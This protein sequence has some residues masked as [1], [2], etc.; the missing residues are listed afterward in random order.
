M[1]ASA[2]TVL[3]RSISCVHT[4]AWLFGQS[5][6]FRTLGISDP[7]IS[8]LKN[9]MSLGNFLISALSQYLENDFYCKF[10]L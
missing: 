7:K 10:V 2:H 5:V 1:Q 9:K 3:H 6:V 8:M 4:R